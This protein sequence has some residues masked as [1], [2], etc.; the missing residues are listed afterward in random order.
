M[1]A[2]VRVQSDLGLRTVDIEI[3]ANLA[4]ASTSAGSSGI[5]DLLSEVLS[6]RKLIRNDARTRRSTGKKMRAER[7]QMA[8]AGPDGVLFPAGLLDRACGALRRSGLSPVIRD[9][10]PALPPPRLDLL[11]IDLFGSRP[12]QMTALS[13]L[14]ASQGGVV[15]AATGY[16]KTE[17]IFQLVR[18]YPSLKILI[19]SYRKDV[20][21]S[22]VSR[23][24][25]QLREPV[26]VVTG[27][28]RQIE[29]VT[30]CTVNSILA[31]DPD[32]W[33]MLIYDEV[34]EAGSDDRATNLFKVRNART[35]GFSATPKGRSDNSDMVVEALFGPVIY[36]IDYEESRKAGLVAAISVDWIK[37]D[38]TPVPYKDDVAMMRH[39]VWRNDARNRAAAFNAVRHLMLGKQVLVFVDKIEHAL[40]LKRYYLHDWPLVHGPVSTEEA[41]WY[42]AQGVLPDRGWLCD[43]RQ[44]EKMR[45]E[46]EAGRLRHAI[47]TGVWSQGV[48]MRCL[49]VLV[50]CDGAS[51]FIPSTQIP[52]RLSRGSQGLLVDF[53]DSYDARLEKRST[54]RLRHYRQHGWS[55]NVH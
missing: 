22:I 27:G 20:V 8:H 6:Y 3:R 40:F 11:D 50:R 14:M 34:H 21:R 47:A 49:D 54:D 42:A 44:R 45:I 28:K 33:Q 2:E 46:F 31:A 35:F 48:D 38:G 37:I 29:R 5:S 32:R 30:V 51:S 15:W 53:M 17:L 55:I 13:H 18:A 4:R 7:R 25:A 12:Q 9:L 24:A 43:A 19:V 36:R 23:G 52:G 41:E 10:R 26:G 16:G 1:H 39:G